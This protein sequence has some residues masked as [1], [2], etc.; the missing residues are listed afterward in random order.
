MQHEGSGHSRPRHNQI[1]LVQR[2]AAGLDGIG[3]QIWR[4][5]GIKPQFQ[6][7]EEVLAVWKFLPEL[8]CIDVVV[9]RFPAKA[10]TVLSYSRSERRRVGAQ[11]YV[12]HSRT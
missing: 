5:T 1:P 6:S 11:R 7:A 2:R 12:G 3:L 10:E 8:N 9:I 4:F